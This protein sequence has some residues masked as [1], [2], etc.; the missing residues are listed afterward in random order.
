MNIFMITEASETTQ[1]SYWKI[2]SNRFKL[3][4]MLQIINLILIGAGD[5]E[6]EKNEDETVVK[7]NERGIVVDTRIRSKGIDNKKK[8][9]CQR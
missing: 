9:L 1:K 8:I 3:R 7:R 2:T 5:E 4:F 6:D